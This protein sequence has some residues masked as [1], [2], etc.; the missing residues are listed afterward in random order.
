MGTDHRSQILELV[1]KVMA[2]SPNPY[3]GEKD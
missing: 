2:K 1:G 3:K